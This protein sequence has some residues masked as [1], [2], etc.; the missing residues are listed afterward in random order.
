MEAKAKEESEK[1]LGNAKASIETELGIAQNEAQEI[2]SKAKLEAQAIINAAQTR[3]ESAESN[4]RLKAEFFIRQT[5]QNV[6]DG[7]RSSVMEICNNLLPTV[8]EF[9]KDS[10]EPLTAEGST[11][12]ETPMLEAIESGDHS[13]ATNESASEES[14][15]PTGSK[16][17]TPSKKSLAA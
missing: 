10:P 2:L 3:A 16:A 7:I 13:L 12:V 8:E 14:A 9:G 15:K 17:K 11:S 6:S 1:L 4:A 5:T